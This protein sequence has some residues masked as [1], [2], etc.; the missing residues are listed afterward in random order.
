MEI[1]RQSPGLSRKHLRPKAFT[2]TEL[3]VLVGIIIILAGIIIP[4][5][6]RSRVK[7][8]TVYSQNNLRQLSAGYL[9]YELEHEKFM[10]YN[11]VAGGAWVEELKQR[12]NYRQDLFFSPI[13]NRHRSFGP[14]NSK[15]AWRQL[16]PE[17]EYEYVHHY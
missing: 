11:K 15:T 13:C 9:G 7:G 14:G 12:E 17:S 8:Y 3:L 2:L 5:L 1:F 4:T 16:A 10:P 6:W